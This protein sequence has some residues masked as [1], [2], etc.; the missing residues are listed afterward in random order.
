MVFGTPNLEL[1]NSSSEIARTYIRVVHRSLPAYV[2]SR[3]STFRPSVLRLRNGAEVGT[4]TTTKYHRPPLIR[5]CLRVVFSELEVR[6]GVD[7]CDLLPWFALVTF[8][9]VLAWPA[10]SELEFCAP[11]SRI[12]SGTVSLVPLHLRDHPPPFHLCSG[13]ALLM[14]PFFSVRDTPT[15]L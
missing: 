11:D 1:P 4:T 9:F 3:S 5:S 6:G 13:A 7:N 10:I 12:R 15:Q 8:V 2:V 14:L